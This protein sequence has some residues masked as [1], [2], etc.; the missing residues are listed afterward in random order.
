MGGR[1]AQIVSGTFILVGIYLFLTNY[2][3]AASIIS[4][5]SSTYNGAVKTLQGR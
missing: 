4:S 2:R 5:V 1:I 3:G